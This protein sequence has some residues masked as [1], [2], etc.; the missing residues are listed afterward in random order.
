[1][2]ADYVNA[3]IWAKI[4]PRLTEQNRLACRCALETGL[5]V[6]DVLKIKP[7]QIRGTTL[8]YKAEKTGKSGTKVLSASLVKALRQSANGGVWCFP[9]PRDP[10]KHRTRQAVWKDINKASFALGVPLHISPH[11]ARKTFAVNTLHEFGIDR[12]QQELQHS[13]RGMTALYAYS[14]IMRADVENSVENPVEKSDL[15]DFDGDSDGLINYGYLSG[16]IADIVVR[17]L[18]IYFE[19]KS[20]NNSQKD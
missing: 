5:R 12:V 15:P 20:E 18:I 14:D 16:L 2:R 4:L 11:S 3:E 6:G 17:R 9:S 13:N 19:S 10:T 7:S 8:R 1:M